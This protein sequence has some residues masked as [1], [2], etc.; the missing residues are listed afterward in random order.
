[1][2]KIS[3]ITP[4]YNAAKFISETI[5]SVIKQTYRDWEMIVVDDC[6]SDETFKKVSVTNHNVR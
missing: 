6:S 2:P 5:E 1:M 4:A 3:V